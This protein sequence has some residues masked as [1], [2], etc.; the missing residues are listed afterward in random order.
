MDT[1]TRSRPWLALPD[2]DS[3]DARALQGVFVSM[4]MNII[5]CNISSCSS[6]LQKVVLASC[7]RL[8]QKGDQ[9]PDLIVDL[10]L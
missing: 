5:C 6:L 10:C 3:T 4:N 8:T 2:P 7:H 9:Q 1:C